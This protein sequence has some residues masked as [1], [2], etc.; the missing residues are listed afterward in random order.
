MAHGGVF[1]SAVFT[2]FYFNV[3]QISFGYAI[4]KLPRVLLRRGN[5]A[6]LFADEILRPRNRT[7]LEF[8]CV[9]QQ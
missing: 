5:G 9:L 1:N 6:L 8:V 4:I 3:L 7:W 2:F